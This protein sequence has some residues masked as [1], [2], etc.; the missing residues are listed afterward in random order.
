MQSCCDVC[1]SIF[2]CEIFKYYAAEL[3]YII[4]DNIGHSSSSEH[5][6]QLTN[7]AAA[8]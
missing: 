3:A 7:A 2:L 5:I 6:F 8:D 4:A 1:K